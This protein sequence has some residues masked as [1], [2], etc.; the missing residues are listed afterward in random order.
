VAL[1]MKIHF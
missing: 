1:F